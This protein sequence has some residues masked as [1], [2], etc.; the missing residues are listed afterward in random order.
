MKHKFYQVKDNVRGRAVMYLSTHDT[1]QCKIQ[2]PQH[3]NNKIWYWLRQVGEF[4]KRTLIF[5]PDDSIGGHDVHFQ[6]VDQFIDSVIKIYSVA[7]G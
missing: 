2:T 6:S 1:I 4:N 3:K 5:T 7:N